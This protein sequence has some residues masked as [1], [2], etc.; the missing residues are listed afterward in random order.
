VLKEKNAADMLSFCGE[1]SRPLYQ[2]PKHRSSEPGLAGAAVSLL[3]PP[4]RYRWGG[5]IV[6]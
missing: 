6:G 2:P 1:S 5:D 4:A 3:H